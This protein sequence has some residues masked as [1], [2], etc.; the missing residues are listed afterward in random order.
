MA[1]N[2]P[3]CANKHHAKWGRVGISNMGHLTDATAESTCDPGL[4]GTRR[5]SGTSNRKLM[6]MGCAR[7]NWRFEAPTVAP[8]VRIGYA[9]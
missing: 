5:Q 3:N 9:R 7:N 8:L 6:H 1:N 4:S 2:T